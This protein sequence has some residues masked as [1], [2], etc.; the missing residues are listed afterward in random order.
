LKASYS[1]R[2]NRPWIQG[3]NPFVSQDDPTFREV[4]NPYL[5][6]E[7]IDA[8]EL[9]ANHFTDLTS[10]TI[11]PYYRRTT[12]VIRRYGDLDSATGVG[13]VTFK[14]F[15]ES[16]SYGADI[17]GSLR[18]GERYNM[19]ASASLYQMTTDASNIEEGLA[20]DAFGWNARVN[21]TVGLLE[22][23]DMQLTWFY[24][25]PWAL[26]GGGEV[27][28]MQSTDIALTQKLLEN[29]LRIGLRVSDVFDQRGFS[30]T[31]TDPQYD[32]SFTRKPSSRTGMLTLSYTFGTPDKNARRRPQAQPN[33]PDMEG[34]W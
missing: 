18:L 11:T 31:R 33:A 9:S 21:A 1:R 25:G 22:G 12:D 26:E 30:V 16:V 19:F 28:P 2:I 23:M 5:K 4:G 17:V 14:N 24:R 29:R 8:I 27:K 10:L 20:S 32:I 13:T 6:P 34:G 3:L 15:D 7:Y